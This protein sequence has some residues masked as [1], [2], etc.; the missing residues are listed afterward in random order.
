M[1]VGPPMAPDPHCMVRS[2]TRRAGMDYGGTRSERKKDKNE[3][4]YFD[5]A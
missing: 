1:T 4:R 3:K 5:K 2:W